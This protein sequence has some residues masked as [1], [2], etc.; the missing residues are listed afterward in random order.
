MSIQAYQR[1]ATQADSPR[2]L[3]YRA[4]GLATAGLMR[5]KDSGR[6]DLRQL[7]EAIAKNRELWM[8]LASDCAVEGNALPSGVRAQIIS[9]SMWV[10]RYSSEVMLAGAEI[11]P[12]ID[13]N[14]SMM[15]GLAGG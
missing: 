8:L 3:E 9:L 10:N 1:A 2:A 11:D 5:A 14:K 6:A 12:L 7:T 15:E 13:V 4:F